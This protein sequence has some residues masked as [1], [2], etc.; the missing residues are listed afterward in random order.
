M[1]H[2]ASPVLMALRVTRVQREELDK[3]DQ[4]EQPEC[5][6]R[7]VRL[8]PQGLLE[9]LVRLGLQAILDNLAR[10]ELPVQL[11]EQEL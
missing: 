7:R 1:A 3:Q 6:V 11:E 9:L 10:V 8:V 5:K 4:L 2:K